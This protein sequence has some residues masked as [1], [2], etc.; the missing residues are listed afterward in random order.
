MHFTEQ[1]MTSV[2]SMTAF[3]HTCFISGKIIRTVINSTVNIKVNKPQPT[4]ILPSVRFYRNF[5]FSFLN[6][7]WIF[8]QLSTTSQIHSKLISIRCIK[9]I[10]R[11]KL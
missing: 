6:D 2:L 1:N 11:I 4:K 9:S 8:A 10:N 7:I 3:K 5:K